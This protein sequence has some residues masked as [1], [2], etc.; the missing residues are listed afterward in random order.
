MTEYLADLDNLIY[1]NLS[2]DF[3][4][5]RDFLSETWLHTNNKQHMLEAK[6]LL[7]EVQYIH[8]VTRMTAMVIL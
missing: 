8:D 6:A 4:R 7:V 5:E 1:G 3:K 2:W